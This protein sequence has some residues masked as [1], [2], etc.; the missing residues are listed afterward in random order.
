VTRRDEPRSTEPVLERQ[1]VADRGDERLRLDQAV[2]R[3]LADEPGVSRTRVQRWLGAGLISVN[4]QDGRRASSSLRLGDEVVVTLPKARVRRV[5]APEALDVPV[6]Y[7]D[8]WL[9][10]VNKPAGMVSHP[11]GRLQSGT[12]FNALLHQ[13]RAW[14]DTTSRP[15]LVHRLDRDT[16]G[17][18]LVAKSRAVHARAARLLA[19]EHASKTYLAVVMGKPPED[20]TITYPLGKI[21]ERPPRVGVVD[22]GWPSVTW[23]QRLRSTWPMPDG[24][25][26]LECT[27]GT[28][29]LHQIRAHLLAA[30]WPIAGDPIYCSAKA[31]AKLPA[32]TRAQVDALEGQ[33]L[34]AW[35]LIMPHP[36]TGDM[37]DV[38]APVPARLQA[39]GVN[40]GGSWDATVGRPR[41]AAIPHA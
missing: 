23:V 36:M 28:G 11:T 8:E 4:G 3:H 13:A 32:M 7:E 14:D 17:V 9:V 24:L 29:R 41:S 38:T 25:A 40:P 34:H 16:S 19:T 37:L 30:G 2:L 18:L 5:H 39:L 20:A 35:R 12:L 27:L 33:A 26:L 22:D 6:L 15:G 1:F 10:V 21:A 31:E